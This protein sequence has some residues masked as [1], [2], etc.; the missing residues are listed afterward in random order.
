[1]TAI[2]R[3]KSERGYCNVCGHE[4]EIVAEAV[5]L[6]TA[7]DRMIPAID[8]TAQTQIPEVAKSN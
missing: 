8:I 2:R 6:G 5:H 7:K 4:V 3:V 1:M